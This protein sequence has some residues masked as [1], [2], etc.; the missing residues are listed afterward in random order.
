MLWFI[1][2]SPL[3]IILFVE[4]TSQMSKRAPRLNQQRKQKRITSLLKLVA[5]TETMDKTGP[6]H[7][8]HIKP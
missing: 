2:N 5:N 8:E 7:G 4:T 6:F 1:V 3:F